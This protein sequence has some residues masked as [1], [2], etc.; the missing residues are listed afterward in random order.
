MGGSFT[1]I[2][3]VITIALLLATPSCGPPRVGADAEEPVETPGS[4]EHAMTSALIGCPH[5][6]L[7]IWDEYWNPNMGYKMWTATCR[8]RTFYCFVGGDIA[9]C[10]EELA[11]SP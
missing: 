4:L 8:D 10:T 7:E 9:E 1:Y 3:P 2:Q 5:Q 11:A 6:E